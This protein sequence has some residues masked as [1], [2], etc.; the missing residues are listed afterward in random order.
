MTGRRWYR[1]LYAQ[2]LIALLAGVAL[3]LLAP[4]VALATKPLG[5]GFIKLIRMLIAPVVFCTVVTGIAGMNRMKEVGKTGALALAYFEVVSTLALALG[6]L[7]VNIVRPGAGMHVDPATLD[8]SAVESYARPGRMP[9]VVDFLLEVIPQTFVGAFAGGDILQVLL[10]AILAGV[11]LHACG[12]RG[13]PLYALVHEGAQVLFRIV[14]MVMHLAPL[15]AFGAMAFT[16][17]RY[18]AATLLSLTQ[19]VLCFYLTCAAFV[20]LV[21]G[22]IARAHGFSVLRFL[23]Y[24]REEL[25]VV[26]GTSSSE[27]ALPGLMGKLERLGVSQTVVGLVVPAGY[28]F[29]LD[30]TAIYLSLAAVFIAQ[31]TGTPLPLAQQVGLL[32]VLLLTSKGAAAVTGGGFIALAATLSTVGHVPVAGLALILGID[33]FMSEA[34]A[35]TNIVGNGIATLVIAR[36]CGRLDEQR[37]KAELAGADA[38]GGPVAAS[39]G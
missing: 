8:A 25:L 28:S 34:R 9:G 2:V 33:K 3:G 4:R 32:A 15:G 18:G 27:S 17:G 30:G 36:W 7:V 19:L 23:R 31:A 6:L 1:S 37:L 29:N 16:I 26:F 13:H 22:A 10:L 35:L 20:L 12:G 14:G 39:A 5:D 21:L 11:G 38:A 24:I